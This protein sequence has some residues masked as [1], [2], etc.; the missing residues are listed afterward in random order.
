MVRIWSQVSTGLVVTVALGSGAVDAAAQGN[1]CSEATLRG[2][3]GIQMEGTRPVPP[4]LGGGTESVIG[5]VVRTYDGQGNF[6]QSD[7]VKGSVT[8]ITPDRP[9]SGTYEV[10]ADCSASTQF[11][12][13]PGTTIVERMVIVEGG[14]QIWSITTS[15]V[16]VM[17]KSVQKKI[18]VAPAAPAAPV[19][20]CPGV[21]PFASIPGLVGEC[22]NGG[23]I[24]RSRSG[25]E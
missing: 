11:Q 13:A 20:P 2:T 25:G 23:W 7:N 15:P 19:I 14:A 18:D 8:G 4:G 17:I 1:A 24:P 6:T 9:G 5:V 12:P 16:P 10:N 21:D 3:Y 22:V